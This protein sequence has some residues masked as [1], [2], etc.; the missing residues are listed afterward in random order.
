MN[1]VTTEGTWAN[2]GGVQVSL[3]SVYLKDCSYESPNGP[4][5]PEQSSLGARNSSST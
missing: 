1:E 5:L 4:R 3:Q 2:V